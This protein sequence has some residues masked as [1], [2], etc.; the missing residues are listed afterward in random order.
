[1]RKKSKAIICG[2]L[3]LLLAIPLAACSLSFG[4]DKGAATE[5]PAADTRE[6]TGIVIKNDVELSQMQVRELDSDIICTLNY[7]A[8][9]QF[10]DKYQS[11]QEGDAVAVGEIR[12]VTYRTDTAR[13][14]A[15]EVPEDVWEYTEVKK[16]SFR[17][18]ENMLTVAGEKYQ[19]TNMTFCAS[20]DMAVEP[21]EFNN[22]DLLTIRGI[23]I[24]AYSVVRT[25]GHGYIR[26]A[27]YG[28]FVG[29]I[30]EI[31]EN[32]LMVQVTENMLITAP[33][34]SQRVILCKNG[35]AAAKTA[36]VNRDEEVVVDFSDYKAAA[37]NIGEVTFEVDPEGADLYINGTYVDYSRPISL[38]YGKY[39]L[40]VAMTG[41][42]T[43]SGILNVEQAS[44]PIRI[45]LQEEDST[46]GDTSATAT[47]AATSASTNND[48]S[49][50]SDD[51]VTKKIDSSHTITVTAPEGAEVF[52]DN[53]YK[54]LAPC[55]FTK[56]IGSQTI[57]LS[58]TGYVTKS[59]SVDILDDGKNVKLSFADLVKD[60]DASAT[61]TPASE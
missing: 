32:G 11:E 53:V 58:D 57:T 7:G 45:E 36:I 34:G 46:V 14:V 51:A 55:T 40:T 43:Y 17:Q 21:M 6:V 42:Q 56:V 59:Y 15:S 2:I 12:K 31:G 22:Q 1:M 20:G 10:L 50:S 3:L 26:L 54:G 52:L 4:K 5:E 61:S 30:A 35:V 16:F 33:E 38:H 28:D 49:T 9:S 19:Y 18:D 60:E 44:K 24:H 25:Q 23:G 41:Y 29:G 8:S 27:N 13:I 37:G 48:S 47:P 39:K